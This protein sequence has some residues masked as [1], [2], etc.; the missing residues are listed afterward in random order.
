MS[1]ISFRSQFYNTCSDDDVIK[2]K[3]FPC[4]WPFVRGIHRS[5]V[6]SPHKGQWRWAFIFSLICALN[7]RL[8]N[9]TW[10]WWFEKLSR[11]LWRHCNLMACRLFRRKTV[12]R[13]NADILPITLYLISPCTKWP[14][15]RRRYFQTR[16]REWKVLYFDLNFTDNCIAMKQA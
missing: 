3:H 12:I 7:K 1:A 16:F 5:P 4:Y 13:T 11:P 2:L 6:N 15:F 10:G 8:S 14:P 9:Q